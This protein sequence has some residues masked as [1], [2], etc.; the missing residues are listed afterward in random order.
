MYPKAFID[1][2]IDSIGR[3]KA[4]EVITSLELMPPVSI[5]YNPFKITL[6]ELKAHFG[7]NFESSVEWVDNEAFYL[8]ERPNFT[9]DPLFHTGAYYVQEASS[10]YMGTLFETI[11]SSL[12]KHRLKVLDLCAAPGGKSTHLLSK[13]SS[14]SLLVTNEVIRSRATILAENIAKWGRASVAVSNNDPKDFSSLRDYFDVILT[15]APCSGEGMFRKN[16]D[17][18]NEWSADNVTLCAARQKRIVSDIWDSLKDGGFLI[19]STCTFNKYENSDNVEWICAQLG[20]ELVIQRQ[21][22]PGQ[23]KGEGF[24]CALLRKHGEWQPSKFVASPKGEKVNGVDIASD[25]L[26]ASKGELLK[27]YPSSLMGEMLYVEQKLR[28]IHSGIAIAT[29]KGKDYI[30][31][32][33]LALGEALKRGTFK[34]VALSRGQALQFLAKE[35]LILKEYPLG[36]LLVTYENIP[37]GFVKNLGNRSNNLLPAARRIR[38]SISNQ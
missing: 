7:D 19:Y 16:Q 22:L 3:Q 6:D 24:F 34:E 9:L 13:L 38:Q 27:A 17:A 11:I 26:F 35:P 33:D 28:V 25:Y 8:K 18:V 37:L 23:D 4:D 12:G 30:P 14:D 1:N 2:L 10:M 5:R 31:E 21:F 36:Y 20:A 29:K 32:A 15:D